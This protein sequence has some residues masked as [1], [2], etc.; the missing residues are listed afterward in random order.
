MIE[1]KKPTVFV[2]A[3]T[4]IDK[5][6]YVWLST[7]QQIERELFYAA[8]LRILEVSPN[9]SHTLGTTLIPVEDVDYFFASDVEPYYAPEITPTPEQKV[10]AQNVASLIDDGDTIQFGIGSLPNALGEALMDKH[11]LGIH[12]EMFSD[13][14]ARLMEAGV[15]TNQKKNLHPGLS[16]CAFAWGSKWLYEYMDGNPFMRVLQVSY[17]ND[18]FVIAQNDNMASVN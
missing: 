12:S 16:I 18:P 7:C 3:V 9:V 5:Y 1:N 2:A 8:D 4:P 14:M 15:V 10:I 11:D 6:G 17:V 13:A